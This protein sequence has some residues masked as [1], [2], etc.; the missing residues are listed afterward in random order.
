MNL[1][2]AVVSAAVAVFA[3]VPLLQAEGPLPQG[4]PS[5]AASSKPSPKPK[6]A[7]STKPKPAPSSKPSPK[8]AASAKPEA[9][10]SPV[11]APPTVT[12]TTDGAKPEDKLDGVLAAL[13]TGYRG[14]A[15]KGFS[16]AA[17]EEN[18]ALKDGKVRVDITV[19]TKAG[20]DAVKKVIAA[21]GGT[22]E[23]DLDTHVYALL[24]GRALR[25]VAA[26][27]EVWT[28]A[29]AQPVAAPFAPKN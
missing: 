9:K 8:P 27:S 28:I 10:P 21:A 24:P 12:E 19:Q 14:G 16:D 29:V 18:V 7:A 15:D 5:P 2:P 1:R 4:L 26:R 6:P 23:A 20:V 22:V 25:P 13:E 3:C 17:G 11:V